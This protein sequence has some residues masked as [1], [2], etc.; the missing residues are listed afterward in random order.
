MSLIEGVMLAKL[1][2]SHRFPRDKPARG[3]YGSVS[4]IITKLFR[5]ERCSVVA[6]RKCVALPVAQGLI[7]PLFSENPSSTDTRR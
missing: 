4:R 7:L 3:W 1:L 6:T 2:F 5:H